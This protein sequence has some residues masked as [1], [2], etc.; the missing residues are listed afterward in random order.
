MS[1]RK[2]S[3]RGWFER[4][5]LVASLGS[6]I[7]GCTTLIQEDFDG[8]EASEKKGPARA[9]GGDGAEGS[10]GSAGSAGDTG[11]LSGACTDGVLNGDET[12]LDCGGTCDPCN[13]GAACRWAGDCVTGVCAQAVCQAPTCFDFVTNGTESDT[14]CG[15][16]VCRTSAA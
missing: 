8:Y 10:A 5:A 15:G 2:V 7:L 6:M 11:V 1:T 3:Q 16:D 12:A 14:D 9:D 13:A 4:V